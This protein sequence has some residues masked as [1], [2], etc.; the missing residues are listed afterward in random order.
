MAIHSTITTVKTIMKVESVLVRSC[1]GPLN[2]GSYANASSDLAEM[3]KTGQ[4]GEGRERKRER[5]KERVK[6]IL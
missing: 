5:K 1:F 4:F 3:M 2:R 6:S